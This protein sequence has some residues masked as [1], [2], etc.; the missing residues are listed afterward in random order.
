MAGGKL[1]TAKN[2]K[3]DEFYTIYDDIKKELV[4][5]AKYFK[6]K[7]IYCNC[8]DHYGIGKGTPKSNFLK[9]L[10]DNFQAF[11]IKKVIATHY[12]AGKKSTM[13]VLTKDNTGDGIICSE[14]IEEI[15]LKGDGDFRSPECIELLKQA[16]IVI[17]NPPFSLFREYV[18]QLIEFNKKF[19]IIGHQNAITY[20]EIFPLI[21]NDKM[22]LGYGFKGGAAHFI[23]EFYT[24]YATASDHRE[25]MIRVSGV[26][27]FTN[28]PT[29]K[30]IE[31]LN[32]GKKYYGFESMYPKY[33]NY[34]AINVDK[35]SDIPMDYSEIIGVP[36]TFLDKY[37][38]DQ[39]EIVALGIVGSCDFLNNKKMEILDKNGK[40]TN[41]FTF[42]AKGTL[43]RKYN[44]NNPKDKPAF[45][46]VETGELYSSIYARVLIRSKKK[47]NT[48]SEKQGE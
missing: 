48:D 30:R 3:R 26:V 19:I 34:N 24:D 6:G 23:N 44:P 36:I 31:V 38:P 25:G 22:W 18:A 46:D 45:R 37:N 40:P 2:N 8:D 39:F 16:D 12:E 7:V 28:L 35:T 13:Y 21:K 9:Y 29:T 47:I 17:T 43:Y 15:P 11:G 14:D 5:Y 32:T 42:N 20:K 1:D 33:E 4:H 41:K 27:W 10:A